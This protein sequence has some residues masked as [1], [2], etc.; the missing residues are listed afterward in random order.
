MKK[1]FNTLFITTQ[2]TYL[3][4]ERET[5]AIHLEDDRKIRFPF[6]NLD[7]IV[8]FGNIRLSPWLIGACGEKGVTVSF[9]NENGKYLGRFIGTVSGNVL[10]RRQ[11]YRVADTDSQRSMIAVNMVIGKIANA[12]T[13]LERFSRDHPDNSGYASVKEVSGKLKK[14]MVRLEGCDSID[15]IRGMEGEAGALYFSVFD[16]LILK[17]KKGFLFSGRNRRPP[18]DSINALLSFLYTLLH[19]DLT[20]ACEA[21]GLDPAVGFLHVDRPGRNS[22]ALDLMEEFRSFMSDRLALSLINRKQI[23]PDD[24][25]KHASGAIYMNDKAKKVVIDAWQSRKK[26]TLQHPFI[27]EK[28]TIG[29]LFFYQALLL[30]RHLRGDLEAYPPFLWR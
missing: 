22:L 4:K 12:R 10:L 16:H 1:I 20:S 30:C 21:T 8:C 14:I 6:H 13:C 28:T 15:S 29:A 11:Q 27:G 26:E 23:S 5:V 9:L 18:L 2:G 17:Q 7:G 3:S 19:H 25:Q 24:F